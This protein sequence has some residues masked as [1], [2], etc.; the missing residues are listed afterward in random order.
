MRGK[1]TK[2]TLAILI[3][4]VICTIAISQDQPPR[5]KKTNG[6]YVHDDA[7]PKP[8]VVKPGEKVGQAPADAIVIFDGKDTKNLSDEAGNPTKWIINDEGAL[9]CTKKAG[10]VRTKQ[11]FGSIQLHIEWA[12]PEKVEGSGQGRGN[13]G[14][15]L[16]GTYELQVLDCWNNPT[17]ADGQAGAIYGQKA[18]LVNVSRAPGEWQTYDVIYHRPIFK[19]KTNEVVRPATITVLHNGVL[20]QDNWEIKGITYHKKTAEYKYHPDKM[21]L[22]LQDHNNAIRYRNIWVREIDDVPATK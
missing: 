20:V 6:Y 15:F 11:E 13:S 21:P 9:E 5:D 10:T 4:T 12:T 8:E 2:I 14:V 22:K 7:E 17:Y 18:P 19:D 3:L 16:Q 1:A